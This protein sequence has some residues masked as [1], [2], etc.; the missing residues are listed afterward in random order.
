MTYEEKGFIW[1]IALEVLVYVTGMCGV[2]VCHEAADYG[3]RMGRIK[4]LILRLGCKTEWVM[5][6]GSTSD[7]LKI[8]HHALHLRIPS[9]SSGNPQ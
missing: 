1:L 4:P 6:Y 9:D 7:D 5:S 8:H 3:G 2:E